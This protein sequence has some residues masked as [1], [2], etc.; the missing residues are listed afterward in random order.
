MHDAL[1][2]TVQRVDEGFDEGSIARAPTKESC[3][4]RIE[5]SQNTFLTSIRTDTSRKAKEC[6]SKPSISSCPIS[7]DRDL[8]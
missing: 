3:A 7:K 1:F 2:T 6:Y 5:T 4:A 8:A